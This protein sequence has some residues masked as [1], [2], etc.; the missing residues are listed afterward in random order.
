MCGLPSTSGRPASGARLRLYAGPIARAA[1]TR[2]A[3]TSVSRRYLCRRQSKVCFV[4]DNQVVEKLRR[5]VPI[6]L[7]GNLRSA[8]G[9]DPND[10][11]PYGPAD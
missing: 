8:A 6:I 4:Q 10:A 3:R 5:M 11:E 7:L 2:T 9:I 1:L